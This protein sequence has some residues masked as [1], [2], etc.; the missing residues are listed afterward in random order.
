[1]NTGTILLEKGEMI[2]H[3][4]TLPEILAAR[5]SKQPLPFS[6]VVDNNETIKENHECFVYNTSDLIGN[7]FE[8]ELYFRQSGTRCCVESKTW[9]WFFNLKTQLGHPK[10]INEWPAFFED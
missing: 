1:M 8:I 7:E 6:F 10:K 4:V 5:I 3:C 9:T 2:G